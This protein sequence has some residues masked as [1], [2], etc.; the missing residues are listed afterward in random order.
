MT[1]DLF[2]PVTE[3][4]LADVTEC[5]TCAAL[6]PASAAEAHARWH[7]GTELHLTTEISEGVQDALSKATRAHMLG[8]ARRA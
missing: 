6:V 1:D 3:A 7:A 8:T 4:M 2:S 5:A